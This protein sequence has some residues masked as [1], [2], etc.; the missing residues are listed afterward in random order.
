MAQIGALS[1]AVSQGEVFNV[2]A[3][4]VLASRLQE[5]VMLHGQMNK[6]M[7]VSGL[8]RNTS[9]DRE[10]TNILRLNSTL[11]LPDINANGAH[12]IIH[13]AGNSLPH[14]SINREDI[15]YY[16]TKGS[17]NTSHERTCCTSSHYG[18]AIALRY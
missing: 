3:H 14:S 18:L 1:R 11:S 7:Y 8:Q 17:F 10:P 4:A 16:I 6:Y 15:S 13:K 5:D 9:I 12:G 2:E